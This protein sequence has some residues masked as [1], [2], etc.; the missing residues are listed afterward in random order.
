MVTK[1]NF[2]I[3][4]IVGTTVAAL[5]LAYSTPV[6]SAG[7]IDPATTT[8]EGA[9]IILVGNK[10]GVGGKTGKLQKPN[11]VVETWP[12]GQQTTV[13]DIQGHVNSGTGD[14]PT[15]GTGSSGGTAT[16]A[17]AAPPP[18]SGPGPKTGR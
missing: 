11:D 17:T 14:Y 16:A 4:V 2:L 15:G 5:I 10:G 13:Q 1:P 3:T 7:V 18:P 8:L 9:Y 12:N 6:M